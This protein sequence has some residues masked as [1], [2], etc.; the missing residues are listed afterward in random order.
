MRPYQMPPP[1]TDTNPF[2]VFRPREKLSRPQTRRK[3]ENDLVAYE[4]M[5][6]IRANMEKG[7]AVLEAI[8]KRERRKRDML[9]VEMEL[10]VMQ[11]RLRHEP[12][13]SLHD[14]VDEATIA[15]LGRTGKLRNDRAVDRSAI[16]STYPTMSLEKAHAGVRKH[17]NKKNRRDRELRDRQTILKQLA[18]PPLPPQPQMLFALD[19]DLVSRSPSSEPEPESEGL[20]TLKPGAY[21]RCPIFVSQCVLSAL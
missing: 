16:T 13:S 19:I 4:K 1:V 12:R 11:L 14:G 5:Q 15:A 10:Q 9:A 17:K 18:P 3:R 20:G 7:I 6:E 21:G 2:N 8:H